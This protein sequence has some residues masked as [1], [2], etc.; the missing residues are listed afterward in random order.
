MP[1]SGPGR[2]WLSISR[3][4]SAVPIVSSGPPKCAT[5][6]EAIKPLTGQQVFAELPEQVELFLGRDG[7]GF[8][9]H[10]VNQ[11]G[12]RRKSFGPHLPV[13]GGRLRIKGADTST[14]PTLLVSG[15][16]PTSRVADG[17]LL[18]DLPPLELFEVVRIG[19]KG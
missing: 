8:V 18:I 4:R 15:E 7:D 3:G 17:D 13:N 9:V 10:L 5:F 12:A 14:K 1:G 19:R 6:L 11:S 2:A 16:G